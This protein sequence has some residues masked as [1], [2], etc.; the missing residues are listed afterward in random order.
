[1][2]AA[3]RPGSGPFFGRETMP[4]PTDADRKHG[5]GPLT[6]DMVFLLRE[7]AAWRLLSLLLES[8]RAGWREQ[9]AALA[10]EAGDAP[11]QQAARAAGDEASPAAY[12]TVFGPGGPIRC[13]EVAYREELLPGKFLA[14]LQGSYE[15]FAYQPNLDEPPDHV[16]VEVGFV[17]YLFFK[18]AYA[19]DRGDDQQAVTTREART[20]FVAEHVAPFAEPFRA[21]LGQ[22][23]ESYWLR[24]AEALTFR[25]KP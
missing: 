10:A 8:P 9:V 6:S 12:A 7:A 23:D 24:A 5:P 3:G 18:E 14:E 11:L 15:A 4:S 17:A 19:L 1:M 25:I 16:A 20:A 21:A 22:I 2:S 13:R